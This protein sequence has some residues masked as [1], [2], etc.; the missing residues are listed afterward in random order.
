MKKILLALLL[1]MALAIGTLAFT[2]CNN[3]NNDTPGDN[4]QGNTPPNVDDENP[5]EN[6]GEDP[7]IPEE[8]KTVKATFSAIEM[9]LGEGYILPAK[10]IDGGVEKEVTYSVGGT[11]VVIVDGM[12]VAKKLGNGSS[13]KI[14]A[15]GVDLSVHLNVI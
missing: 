6:P 2:A 5:G 15:D 8:D 11:G 4:G 9:L 14:S 3:G 1:I 7:V 12:L 13:L 10:I